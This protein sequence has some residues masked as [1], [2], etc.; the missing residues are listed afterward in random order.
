MVQRFLEEKGVKFLL[1]N[2]VSEFFAHS[3]KMKNGE[4]VSYDAVV[5]AVGVR[6]NTELVQEAG[7]EVN[8]GIVI[9]RTCR[10]SLPDIY[11]AGDCSEGYDSVLGSNR[12]LALLPN[13][14]MQGHCAGVNMAGGAET[15]DNAIPMNAIGFFGLHIITAGAYD[16]EV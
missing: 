1:N 3:A 12:I 2:S 13:A 4:I 10:T 9:D 5:L 14:Y 15:F 7:G 8:R 16:G 6:P 11:C